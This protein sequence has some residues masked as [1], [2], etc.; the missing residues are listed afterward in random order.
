VCKALHKMLPQLDD[1]VI[2]AVSGITNSF[3][4]ETMEITPCFAK[5]ISIIQAP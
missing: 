3:L 1:L 2:A 4:V 5:A